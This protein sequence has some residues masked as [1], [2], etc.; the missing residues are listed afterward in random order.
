M[1]GNIVHSIE[2][3]AP[4]MCSPHLAAHLP[5]YSTSDQ[6]VTRTP[7]D[8]YIYTSVPVGE[9]FSFFFEGFRSR[10]LEVRVAT[11]RER[12]LFVSSLCPHEQR[13][14]EGRRERRNAIQVRRER[15]RRAWPSQSCVNALAA[16]SWQL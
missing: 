1:Y 9:G 10:E 8:E 12:G 4:L 15:T 5:V 7:A 14:E 11:D 6:G 16:Q 2:N 3:A 13:G